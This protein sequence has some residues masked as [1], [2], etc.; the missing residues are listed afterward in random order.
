MELT[1][2]S[3][4]SWRI[5]LNVARAMALRYSAWR[6]NIWRRVQ[7]PAAFS[8]LRWR[9]TRLNAERWRKPA[10]V[11]RAGCQILAIRCRY[12]QLPV[13]CLCGRKQSVRPSTVVQPAMPRTDE[14]RALMAGHPQLDSV[15]VDAP[16]CHVTFDRLEFPQWWQPRGRFSYRL[17]L[18]CGCSTTSC[19]SS[20]PDNPHHQLRMIHRGP[21]RL[22]PQLRLDIGEELALRL[23]LRRRV[24][25]AECAVDRS[26]D[27]AEKL[28]DV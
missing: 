13:C 14:R 10:F 6:L 8:P 20:L 16:G 27:E 23:V 18:S 1:G 21:Q 24:V 3:T 25:A 15:R 5:R 22:A 4:S 7:T 19:S 17:T 26:S 11:R 28:E 9:K 12:Q 2:S